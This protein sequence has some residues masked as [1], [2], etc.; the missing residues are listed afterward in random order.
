L[1]SKT[2]VIKRRV[3]LINS[4]FLITQLLDFFL[5]ERVIYARKPGDKGDDFSI[6]NG[7]PITADLAMVSSFFNGK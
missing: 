5:P 6:E 1:K 7:E 4:C 2:Q 3:W